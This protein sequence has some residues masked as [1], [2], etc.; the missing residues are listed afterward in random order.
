MLIGISVGV[1]ATLVLASVAWGVK[2]VFAPG[3][4]TFTSSC[5]GAKATGTIWV[6]NS[7]VFTSVSVVD[8]DGRDWEVQ[9]GRYAEEIAGGPMKP[10]LADYTGSYVGAAQA[11]GDTDGGTRRTVEVRPEGQTKWCDLDM[12]VY[13]F[14]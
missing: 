11:L 6:D 9:W 7:I 8:P 5:S 2:N 1:L 3:P 10:I 12:R 4:R 14:W 13:L